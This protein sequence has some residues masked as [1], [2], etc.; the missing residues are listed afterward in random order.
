METKEFLSRI[1]PGK[2]IY[3]LAVLN[4]GEDGKQGFFGSIGALATAC[5]ALDARSQNVFYSI[6][7]FNE[8]RRTKDNVR[9]TKVVAVDVDCG[10]S[11]KYKNWQEGIKGAYKFIVG[12]KLPKPLIIHSGRGL[13]IYWVFDREL[14]PKEWLPI[15]NALKAAAID[16][17]FAIDA[18]LTANNALLLRPVGTHNIKN[19]AE[20]KVL[21]DAPPV[22]VEKI[23]TA[24]RNYINA[25]PEQPVRSPLLDS[26]KV[27]PNT[28]PSNPA[29]IAGKCKQIKW[30]IE[31][32]KE[33]EEP[34]WYSLLGVA[35]FC[36][37]SEKTALEWSKD[38]PSFSEPATLRK[39][40]QWQKS[41]TGPTTCAKF[42]TDRPAGCRGCEYQGKITTPNQLGTQYTA[43]PVAL[44]VPDSV[45]LSVNIPKPFKRTQAGI[46]MTLNETDIQV[47]PFDFYP[48]SYGFD[49]RL[50][51][52][53]VRFKWK[54]NF[55]GWSDLVFRQAYL[56][57]G[58]REFPTAIADQGIVL[59]SSDQTA[60]FQ[61]MSRSYMNELRQIRT[62]TNLYSTMGWKE[63]KS[64]FVIGDTVLKRKDDGTVTKDKITLSSVV[65]RQGLDLFVSRGDPEGW[66]LVTK[67]IAQGS[68]FPHMF[69]LNVGF[70]APLYA[71]T[72]L[73]GI[74]ISF[75]GPTGGGK[76]IA[77]LWVQSI[78]GDPDKLHF[79][80]KHTQYSVFGRMGMY[81]HLPMTIDEVTMMPDKEV[82]DFCY[83]VTQGQDK[84]RL[85]RNTSEREAK[86]WSLPVIV[87]TNTSL[88]AKLIA[89]K[90]DTD[91]QMARLLELTIPPN[92]L[93]IRDSKF[94]SL[95][96]KAI[97]TNYGHAGKAFI[98]KL[99]EL[100]NEETSNL[101]KDA[102]ATF[103]MKY[104]TKF[105][106]QERYWEQAIVLSDLAGR[107]AKEW[108]LIEYDYTKGTMWVL[109]QLGMIRQS[110]RDS[111]LDTY[112]LLADYMNEFASTTLVIENTLG[113]KQNS[114]NPY[115]L[116]KGEV[117]IRID[118]YRKSTGAPFDR[119][120]MMLDRGHFRSWLS[121]QG[122]DYTA[123]KKVLSEDGA[124]ATPRS[125][126]ASMGKGTPI[127]LAQSYVVGVNL[128]HPRLVQILETASM[129]ADDQTLG[130]LR[131]LQ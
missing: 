89:S 94:G 64:M 77:Q 97:H 70:S 52:E 83:W 125:Q 66:P 17:E 44:D 122:G 118:L 96:H 50:G 80:A 30:A 75:Y 95:I 11:K 14:E 59:K 42:K 119:G 109:E 8:K 57:A 37:E 82:G 120:T 4:P 43:I 67:L 18:G 40:R 47:C 81:C 22:A 78:Y 54:R 91:A 73:K 111:N 74:T 105:T 19:K 127:K 103:H 56:A 15:A 33:V 126:K 2:G 61:S 98:T 65:K 5:V 129:D 99:M 121:A 84:I 62:L 53:V 116:P 106:G 108:G 79:T 107:L 35:A 69:A 114:F 34:L 86:T 45:A 55:V 131:S 13:H 58:S 32:Q 124:N 26:L 25:T 20:V 90:F 39:L 38:Y 100:G 115:R 27:T 46:Y 16:K 123:F 117:R 63:S 93:F 12:M 68:L 87:S 76:S 48:V 60:L 29:I 72:G 110:V 51:Y 130:Q 88:Q 23:T 41:A 104:R 28:P 7:A 102:N 24:L 36:E 112:D 113:G 31:N 9:A 71:F 128:T 3:A 1:L 10:E 6:S 21:I 49:E 92:K 85:D 101:I